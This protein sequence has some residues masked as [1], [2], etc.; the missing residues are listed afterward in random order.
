MQ[1]PYMNAEATPPKLKVSISA[2]LISG[3]AYLIPVIGGAL[4]SLFLMNVLR[5][6]KE[7]ESVGKIALLNAL[8]ESTIPALGSL[9]FGIIGGLIVIIVLIIR[10]FMQTKTASPSVFFF[11]FCGFLILVPAGLFFEAE[12][13]MIEVLIDPRNAKNLGEIGSNVNLFLILSIVSA[14]LAFIIMLAISVIPFSTVSK[15]KWSPLIA[16]V[17]IEILIIAAAV[18]FQLRFLWLYNAGLSEF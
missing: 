13:M 8:S 4:S 9:Y 11:I 18:A 6:L 2:R 10:S 14:I 12:S 1:N 15:P 3:L 7:S 16:A 17:L 5:I